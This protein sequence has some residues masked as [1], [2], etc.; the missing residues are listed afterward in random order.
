MKDKE[1]AKKAWRYIRLYCK[2]YFYAWLVR[3]SY[4][5]G[6]IDSWSFALRTPFFGIW[7]GKN[8]PEVCSMTVWTGIS[9]MLLANTPIKEGDLI[10]CYEWR[11]VFNSSCVFG[12]GS[13]EP[14][15]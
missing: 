7:F 1:R 2:A 15:R 3:G 4:Y 6:K 12:N 10:Y 9:L 11:K 14:I 13:M 5:N 8:I